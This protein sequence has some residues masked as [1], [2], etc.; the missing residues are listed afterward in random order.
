MLN[1]N[2]KNTS[3]FDLCIFTRL[4]K[5]LAA[6]LIISMGFL[7]LNRFMDALDWMAPQT[8]LSCEVDCCYSNDTSCCFDQEHEKNQDEDPENTGQCQGACDCSYS[9]QIASMEIP[10]QSPLELSSKTYNHGSFHEL[11]YF[12]YLLPHFQPPRKA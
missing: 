11:Y 10:I 8:E 1:I 12:E 7:G 5:V 2:S 4:M 3:H 9:I 6:I